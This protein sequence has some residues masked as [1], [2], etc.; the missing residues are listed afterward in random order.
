MVYTSLLFLKHRRNLGLVRSLDG[1]WAMSFNSKERLDVL[2]ARI[3]L[4]VSYE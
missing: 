1:G 2:F 4:R 3:I